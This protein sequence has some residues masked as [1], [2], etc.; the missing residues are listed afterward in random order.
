MRKLVAADLFCG[1]G[2]F[3]LGAHLSGRVDVRL[4]NT[5][6]T[7]LNTTIDEKFG[8]QNIVLLLDSPPILSEEEQET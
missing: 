5:I 7:D 6:L 8:Q 4:A 2:G 1:A 3:T